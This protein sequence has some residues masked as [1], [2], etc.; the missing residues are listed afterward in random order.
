M[1]RLF[2][3][4][5]LAGF[6]AACE[7]GTGPV[8]DLDFLAAEADYA[9][10]DSVFASE[11][12]VSFAALGPRTPFGAV[13]SAVDAL[14]GLAPAEPRS[15]RELALRLARR[16]Q[17]VAASGG[18]ALTPIIS[19]TH[20]GATFVYDAAL[21]EYAVD[22]ARTGAPSNGV[23]F[24]LYE[25]DFLGTPMGE[26]IGY[27]D[28]IDEG[29]TSAEDVALRLVVVAHSVTVLDYATTLELGLV[30]G[31]LTVEGFLQSPD[32]LRL[33]FDIEATGR[34]FVTHSELD[35]AFDLAVDARDFGIMGTVT[36]VQ[37]GV[38]GEGDVDL[39]V[40]H[41]SRVVRLAVSGEAGEIDGT[42]QIDGEL[43]ATIQGPA[44]APTILSADGDA[45]TTAEMLVLHRVIDVVEDV[46]DFLE[47]LI[48]PV[49][50]IV[51]LGVI[52]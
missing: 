21:D 24:M 17:E 23:R 26:E 3:L 9:A 52:L 36:G 42:V 16:M 11:G 1:L 37:E 12:W 19:E 18:P 25:V 6:T 51:V 50:E 14:G 45:L 33:D 2:T 32:G 39:T 22:P 4:T 34:H 20:R 28:L 40:H 10:M 13:S 8:I 44:G 35:V 47:D 38:D 5:A 31:S 7:S 49:D 43:F 30:Q 41:G 48:D 29:D 46:F 27:A 15:G